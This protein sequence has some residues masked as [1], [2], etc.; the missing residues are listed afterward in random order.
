MEND[1]IY[2]NAR[3]KVKAKKGFFYHLLAYVLVIGMLYVI[4]TSENN[5]EILP[6][7]IVALSWGIGLSGHYFK[8]FGTEH[9][10]ILGIDPDWEE[11]ELEKEVERMTRKRELKEKLKKEKSLLDEAERLELKEIVKRPLDADDYV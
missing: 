6:V 2:E 7:I 5:G 8:A 9:L 10:G 11:E 3:K 4:I 1:D